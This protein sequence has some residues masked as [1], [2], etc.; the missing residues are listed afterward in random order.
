MNKK[1]EL[2]NFFLA[3]TGLKQL[4][5]AGRANVL[6]YSIFKTLPAGS[7][8]LFPAIMCTSPIIVAKLA[9]M[10][11]ILADVDPTNGLLT[12]ESVQE[13]LKK[14][15]DLKAILSVNLYGQRPDNENIYA[16][17]QD[18]KIIL[19]EDAALGWN[20]NSLG[21]NVDIAVLSFGSKKPVD[22]NGGGA[23]LTNNQELHNSVEEIIK[24]IQFTSNE[25]IQTLSGL[26]T[27]LYYLLQEW[28]ESVPTSQINFAHFQ[29]A[30]SE[31]YLK[32]DSTVNLGNILSSLENYQENV[33][34]RF[35]WAKKYE[36]YFQNTTLFKNFMHLEKGLG[37]WRYSVMYTGK[38]R[39]KFLKYIRENKLD[40]SSWYPSLEKLGFGTEDSKLINAQ[41]FSDRVI[42]FWVSDINEE[43][44]SN[45]IKIIDSFRE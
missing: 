41:L 37:I 14:H 13:A 6:L 44:F 38:N 32:D 40:V 11:A 42:N 17:C 43:I 23:A 21:K 10:Q 1:I 18:N 35:Y 29:D 24:N 30:L 36:D 2:E 31:L 16:L 9:N 15:P 8:I 12:E 33:E 25:K 4:S 34:S 19:I 20:F 5:I 22:C 27:R 26:Y 3:Q 45:T 28:E 7:K 39:N